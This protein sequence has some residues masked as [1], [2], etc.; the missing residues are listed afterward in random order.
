M[1]DIAPH[2]SSAWKQHTHM[3][4]NNLAYKEEEEAESDEE[5]EDQEAEDK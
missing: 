5:E 1:L 3:Y 2:S 4:T